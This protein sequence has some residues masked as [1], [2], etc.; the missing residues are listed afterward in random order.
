MIITIGGR[1]GAGK[2]EVGKS[3]AKALGY[4]FYSAGDVRR[5]YA[6]DHGMI[7]DELNERAKTDPTSDFLVD[8][9]MKEIA[10]TEDDLVVDAWLGPHFFSYSIKIYLDAEPGL[11]AQRIFGRKKPEE[12]ST[13]VDEAFRRMTEKENCSAERYKRLYGVDIY[14]KSKYDLIFD[15]TGR[16]VTDSTL[17]LFDYIMQRQL[18]K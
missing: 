17:I 4:G 9:Y 7:I 16:T 12:L 8:N 14:D 2:S 15:T 18:K 10:K 6:L 1:A 11:R 13:T 3:L 5:K